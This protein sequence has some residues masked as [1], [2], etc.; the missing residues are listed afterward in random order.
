MDR[1]VVYN[2]EFTDYEDLEKIVNNFR[3]ELN[4]EMS[5]ATN[6]IPFDR[7]QKEKEYLLPLP[8]IDILTSYIFHD[9]E[10][11]VHK[12]SMISFKG[13]RYSVPTKYIGKK[14]TLTETAE[15]T[16]LIHYTND[17]IV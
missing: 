7:F 8:N 9:K 12:D 5:Q 14:V 13:K 6:E 17:L 2:E 15:D 11:K 1:L 10:Y 3:D 16:L 4:Y